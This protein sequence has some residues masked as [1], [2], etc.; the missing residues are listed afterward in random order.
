MRILTHGRLK[1]M[2]EIFSTTR[3]PKLTSVIVRWD[4]FSR[5]EPLERQIINTDNSQSLEMG[6]TPI[7]T[8]DCKGWRVKK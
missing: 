5:K 3:N 1:T 4:V 8:G 6:G 2:S 7:R